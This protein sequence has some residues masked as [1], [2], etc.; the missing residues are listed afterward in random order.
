MKVLMK[1]RDNVE[2]NL[3]SLAKKVDLTPNEIEVA[4]N[5]VCLMEKIDKLVKGE[6]EDEMSEGYRP[7]H[8]PN[9][10]TSYGWEMNPTPGRVYSYGD[11][12]YS[13]SSMMRGRDA[14]TGQFTSRDGRMTAHDMD[15]SGRR[16]RSRMSY[17]GGYSGHSID[18]RIIDKLEQMM[19][20]AQSEYEIRK[21][22]QIIRVV[23][24]MKGE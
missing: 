11:E 15:T 8:Y 10:R 1:L 3:E 4:T 18:D 13:D 16:M 5:A 2:T 22:N 9:M 23:E 21:I 20:S 24:S 7:M 6:R 14:R 17:D 12:W 19:D